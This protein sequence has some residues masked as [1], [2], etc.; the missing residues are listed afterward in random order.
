MLAAVGFPVPLL[1][2]AH[3]S[4]LKRDILRTHYHHAGLVAAHIGIVAVAAYVPILFPVILHPVPV[5]HAAAG[6]GDICRIPDADSRFHGLC[7]GLDMV[8]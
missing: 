5:K 3:I 8:F 7:A 6:N 1:G 2:I 4:I